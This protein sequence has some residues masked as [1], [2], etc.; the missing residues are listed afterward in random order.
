MYDF[1]LQY[2]SNFIN[3]PDNEVPDF[4]TIASNLTAT[5][6]KAF[7]ALNKDTLSKWSDL[8]A[9]WEM[10]QVSKSAKDSKKYMTISNSTVIINSTPS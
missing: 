3:W 4:G 8:D 6:I 5:H 2:G 9:T 10:E 1:D 7:K